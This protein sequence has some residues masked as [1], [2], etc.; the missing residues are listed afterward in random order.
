VAGE[1][2]PD[3]AEAEVRCAVAPRD[4]GGRG[5]RARVPPRAAHGDG[6]GVSRCAVRASTSPGEGEG[7]G[8][9]EERGGNEGRRS[10]DWRMLLLPEPEGLPAADE[11]YTCRGHGAV[12]GF[13]RDGPPASAW[14]R[15]SR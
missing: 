15:T 6:A 9:A 14:A 3:L 1:E 4:G 7:A 10:V 12:Y 8:A 13:V 5:R 11:M 2:V